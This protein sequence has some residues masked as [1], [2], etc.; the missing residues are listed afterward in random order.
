MSTLN[1][2]SMSIEQL[3][4]KESFRRAK[5]MPFDADVKGGSRDY[6]VNMKFAPIKYSYPT[7]DDFLREFEPE[8]HAINSIKY[9]PNCLWRDNS[10]GKIKAKIRSRV[11]VAWQK[12]IHTKR[13]VALTGYDPDIAIAKSRSDAKSQET[14]ASFKEG[15]MTKGMDTAVHMAISADLKVGDTAFCGYKDGGKFGYRLFSYDKG[16]ILY[17]HYDPMTGELA[18]FARAYCKTI[19]V[20]GVDENITI[21]D[22]W[23]D[24]NFM[25]Y[26]QTTTAERRI[27]PSQ[28]WKVS[29]KPT[30]HAF[31]FCPVSYHR[32]GEPC[33]A[34]SQSLIENYELA[35]SQLAE[36][37]AQYALR[38]LY[39]LGAEF[40]MEGTLDG[41][42]RQ[43]NSVDPNAKV[44]FLEPADS[45]NSFSLQLT[46]LAK[47]IMKVSFAVET[48]ELKSGSDVSSLTVKMLFADSYQKAL[49]DAREY[50]GFLDRIIRI[51]IEGYGTEIMKVA[52]F[53]NL[54]V[55]VRLQP[56]CFM[57]ESE[58]VNTLVQL[59]SV[60][61]LSKESAT[62][63]AY[64]TLGLGAVDEVKRILQEQH[65][66]LVGQT[67]AE[68][69]LKAE[70]DNPVNNARKVIAQN[71]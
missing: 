50:Q 16:D 34:A 24:T 68:R 57:A 13:L 36:N 55:I 6:N 32:Y 43:I 29:M 15:W 49:E 33:W 52:D 64:E 67:E 26:M 35:I 44:G 25:Q 61:V 22:V 7:Q 18:V 69:I 71:S 23:D 2:Q 21:I 30:P 14:L 3:L 19:K 20:D 65:D 8:S 45:S 38:I 37:N 40:D 56:W 39:A 17:P 12:K 27:N 51:F 4:T 59:V 66:E 46:T 47:E 62:E 31:T 53:T 60:G 58:V 63:Y 9:Y 41:T 28:E 11:A 70:T 54:N 10:D 5:P 42:P 48:P 1:I